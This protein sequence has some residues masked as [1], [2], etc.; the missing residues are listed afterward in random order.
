M[1]E[2]GRRAF[3]SAWHFY[4]LN[5]GEKIPFSW[6]L[7]WAVRGCP[8]FPNLSNSLWA[9]TPNYD[10]PIFSFPTLPSFSDPLNCSQSL[11]W[12]LLWSPSLVQLMEPSFPL[13]TNVLRVFLVRKSIALNCINVPSL[14]FHS[15]PKLWTNS[16]NLQVLF[17]YLLFIPE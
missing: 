17:H 12:L 10:N 1:P 9:F 6:K 4:S 5:S 16:L 2:T 11:L 15:S 14:I 8:S 13:T 3:I 7:L